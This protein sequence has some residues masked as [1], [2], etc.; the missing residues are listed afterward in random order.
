MGSNPTRSTERG[1]MTNLFS[2][3]GGAPLYPSSSTTT[4]HLQSTCSAA[5]SGG[6]LPP[7]VMHHPITCTSKL[8]YEEDG[9]F[10]CEHYTMPPDDPRTKSCVNHSIVLLIVELA[11][12]FNGMDKLPYDRYE[13]A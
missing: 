13:D 5:T 11:M 9:S 1:I 7:G 4:P 10:S 2:W 6:T 3:F 8:Y 12:S